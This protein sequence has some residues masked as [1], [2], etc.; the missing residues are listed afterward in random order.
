MI[1][2]S[3]GAVARADD[4]STVDPQLRA[5]LP[6]DVAS[7]GVLKIAIDPTAPPCESFAEDNK[8]IVGFE[9][10]MWNAVAQ[11]FGIKIEADTIDFGGLI[12]GVQSGRYT[13]AME[14]MSDLPD[15]EAKVTFVD[16]I[17]GAESVY[18]LESNTSIT[19]EPLTL[20]GLTGAAQ[21]ATNLADTIKNVLAVHCTKNG[22]PA[23]KLLEFASGDE[24]LLAVYSGRADFAI[25]DTAA[26]Q[27]VKK[28][29]P[30]PVRLVD[31][32]YMPRTYNGWIV[33]PENTQL[34]NALLAGLKAIKAN[35]TYDKILAKWDVELLKLDE[36]AINLATS[37][38]LVLPPP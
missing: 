38:P 4:A 5:L 32:V 28:H 21:T 9:P 16:N 6:A 25:A 3:L 37:K 22:K 7:S 36:P 1:G 23:V 15:R 12:P 18:T 26:A 13:A 33:K 20:C 24:V 35:G 2:S 19:S 34:A 27:E 30:R 11:K 31:N 8:T 10:D 14:C 17:F 29:A